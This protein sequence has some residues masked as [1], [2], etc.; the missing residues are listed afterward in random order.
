VTKRT[1]LTADQRR[2]RIV[3]A[4]I[5][6]MAQRG[7]D[8]IS[9]GE[10]AEAAGCSK[11]VLYD[12][13]PSK[14]QLAIAA[15]EE[16]GAALME[17]TTTAVLNA[18][19]ESRQVRLRRGIDAFFEFTEQ[20]REACRMVFR[21]PSHDPEVFA[22]HMRVHANSSAGVAA[23][24]DTG[25]AADRPADY[26]RRLAGYAHITTSLLAG[27]ALWWQDHPEM[28]REE[29]VDLVMSYVY[30]GLDRLSLGERLAPG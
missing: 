20:N 6:L 14:A 3:A 25:F 7:Y 17:H 30:L 8:A 24:L 23:L 16:M 12:H 13:F 5:D 1:R 2:E 15:V 26:E 11:A 4:A 21:D 18:A 19:G 27:M 9:V 28:T 10:I 29:I 22:A